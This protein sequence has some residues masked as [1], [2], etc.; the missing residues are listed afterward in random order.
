MTGFLFNSVGKKI[1]YIVLFVI[2]LVLF[3]LFISL[4]FFSKIAQVSE[5]KQVA[6]KY[7]VLIGNAKFEF[8]KYISTKSNENLDTFNKHIK[9]INIT[10]KTIGS[11]YRSLKKGL[12][13]DNAVK[14]LQ[15]EVDVRSG[16]TPAAKLIDNLMGTSLVTSLVETANKAHVVTVNWRKLANLYITESSEDQKK[17]FVYNYMKPRKNYRQ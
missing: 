10:D 4:F 11:L 12:S 3:I 14:E 1:S 17:R 5:V 13:I 2:I 16:Q 9:H 8:E 15:K 6:Y 7:E